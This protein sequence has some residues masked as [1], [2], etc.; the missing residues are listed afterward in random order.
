MVGGIPIKSP[1]KAI[2]ASL[3]MFVMK[4]SSCGSLSLERDLTGRTMLG[5]QC[6]V[7]SMNGVNA[8]ERS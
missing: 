6:L 1:N 2:I 5:G 4:T 8:K 7:T 3:V